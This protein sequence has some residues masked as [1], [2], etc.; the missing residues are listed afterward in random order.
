ML[1]PAGSGCLRLQSVVPLL[2]AGT[3]A[4][5][6]QL[7][8]REDRLPEPP[9]ASLA[10]VVAAVAAELAG[11]PRRRLLLVGISL[12]GLL[13]YEL[14]LALEAAG[15]AAAGLLVLAARAPE[16][17]RNYPSENLPETEE[18]ALL[19]PAVRDSAFA[20]YASAALRADLRLTAGYELG[21]TALATTPLWTA[22]GSRD[23]VVTIEQMQ[24]WRSRSVDFR[25]HQV[26]DADHHDIT[27]PDVLADSISALAGYERDARR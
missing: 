10:E 14:G 20:E 17:W 18:A 19:P 11:L 3:H 5:G 8:G 2:P 1:P 27:R 15:N 16:F 23:E 6:V 21:P 22:S 26:L 4:F 25:S 24:G 9:A 13:A 12:G 7:P